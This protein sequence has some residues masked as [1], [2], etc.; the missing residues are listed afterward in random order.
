M[1]VGVQELYEAIS[2]RF[3]VPPTLLAGQ[4]QECA[5]CHAKD[6]DIQEQENQASEARDKEKKDAQTVYKSYDSPHHTTTPCHCHIIILSIC[7]WLP[8]SFVCY[9]S[10]HADFPSIDKVPA[11]GKYYVLPC[12]WVADWKEYI[13]TS[14]NS[15]H[16]HILSYH[17]YHRCDCTECS[18]RTH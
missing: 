11:A 2:F 1:G 4:A 12:N 5:K 10:P 8:L 7:M 14:G 15:L 9:Y 18:V 3:S 17:T 6:L 16:P 13:K